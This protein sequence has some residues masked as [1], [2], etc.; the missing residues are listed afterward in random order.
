MTL[1]V[2]HV[3][4][5]GDGVAYADGEPV[6]LP[7]TLAGEVV[8][9]AVS[10]SRG[11]V[12]G[13]VASSP[14]R[15]EPVCSHFDVCGGCALQHMATD[16]YVDWK[17]QR[18]VDGLTRVGLAVPV[19]PLQTFPVASRRRAV[20]TLARQGRD[21]TLGFH[22][23]ASDQPV[24]LV[25]CPILVSAIGAQ[26]NG[27]RA[28]LAGF[29]PS[30]GVATATVL[31]TETGLDVSI[32]GG[33]TPDPGRTA[34]VFDRAGPIGVARLS[35]N[36][37]FVLQRATPILRFDGVPVIPP[38]GGFV[39]ASEAAQIAMTMAVTSALEGARRVA[40]LYSG[41]GTFTL[42]L[43]KTARVLA[44]ESDRAALAALEAA[45]RT[46][47]LKQV[48]AARRDL[49]RE[50]V[51]APELKKIDGLVFDPPRAGARAQATEIAASAVPRV[52]AVSCNPATFARD[53]Q[54][55]VDG[56]YTLSRVTPVDQFRFAPHI[57]IIA[58]FQR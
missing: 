51:T 26:L 16:D 32:E 43:A 19:D 54:I 55:L 46:P 44:F 52:V 9:A 47:G 20:F 40:D 14:H 50:P 36:G 29:A 1:T 4:H 58:V 37:E 2:D 21:P 31:A 22:A 3:G 53:A 38:P 27:L 45:A 25:E 41:S 35:V 56:G 48:E 39:Q 12:T 23:R 13:L 57:E 24:S 33:T 28:M 15:V 11:Q 7:N 10:G 8:D 42:P 18:V 17:R 49:E 34:I 6:Y 30:H 5:R